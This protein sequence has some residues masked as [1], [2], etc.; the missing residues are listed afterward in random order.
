[1]IYFGT[2][3][4]W[5]PIC[6]S[7]L[8]RNPAFKERMQ[9]FKKQKMNQFQ[10]KHQPNQYQ[11]QTNQTYPAFNPQNQ[12]FQRFNNPNNP[13]AQLNSQPQQN[14]EFVNDIYDASASKTN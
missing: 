6:Y 9:E 5:S 10:S 14:K 8:A 2:S 4:L 11:Q 3:L 7:E 13:Y 1:M 12:Q